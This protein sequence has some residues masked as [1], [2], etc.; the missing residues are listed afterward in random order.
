MPG[1]LKT[2][3]LTV[4]LLRNMPARVT[5]SLSLS[6]LHGSKHPHPTLLLALQV[7]HMIDGLGPAWLRH[8]DRTHYTDAELAEEL[9]LPE[10]EGM[11]TALTPA[12]ADSTPVPELL[13]G[14]VDA[15]EYPAV[16]PEQTV[17]DDEA[18]EA[19]AE[20]EP[21]E[22]GGSF[23]APTPAIEPDS[24]AAAADLAEEAA[25]ERLAS[26]M[27]AVEGKPA[28]VLAPGTRLP[29]REYLDSTVV[30]V[31]REGLR[32]LCKER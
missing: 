24:H 31:L 12:L 15:Q 27:P 14:H 4:L 22:Y 6:L 3:E 20:A 18:A 9:A 2:Q 10:G 30:P 21:A 11:E 1:I 8:L 5:T 7:S 19:E 26:D 13:P 23:G 16:E 28:P 32:K 25:D 17:P 29:V